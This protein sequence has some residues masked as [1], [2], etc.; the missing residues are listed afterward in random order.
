MSAT[1]ETDLPVRIIR[2]S[3]RRKTSQARLKDGY[4]EVR[5]PD[6]LST[7]EEQRIITKLLESLQK[8]SSSHILGDEELMVVAQELN[9]NFLEGRAQFSSIR[10][11]DNQNYRWGSCTPSQGSIRISSRLRDVPPYVLHAVV[12]HELVHT[13]IPGGH[14]AEF[15]SWAYKAPLVERA[16]GFLEAYQR[17]G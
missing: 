13:F 9:E 1:K 6:F 3:K 10:W 4:I 17:Y 12:I 8:K 14:S 2:S 16:R 5:I 7:H 15:W 11:V